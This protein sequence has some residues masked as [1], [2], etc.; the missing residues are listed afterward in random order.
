MISDYQHNL[1]ITALRNRYAAAKKI[2]NGLMPKC[3]K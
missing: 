1:R 3:V 2:L